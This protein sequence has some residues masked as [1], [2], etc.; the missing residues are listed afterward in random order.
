MYPRRCLALQDYTLIYIP[1][2]G[3]LQYIDHIIRI[4]PRLHP[5][6]F[7]LGCSPAHHGLTQVEFA[8]T[9]LGDLQHFLGITV[10]HSTD[11][12]LLSHR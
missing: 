11:G 4:P 6:R 3:R 7:V 5:H 12:L 8:M 10:T 2:K 9:D 1:P